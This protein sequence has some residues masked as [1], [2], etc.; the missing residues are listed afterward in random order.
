MNTKKTER[1]ELTVLNKS[2][3]LGRVAGHIRRE[4]WN[5]KRL[6][7]DE[8]NNSGGENTA[9][10]STSAATSTMEIDI[11]G[12]HTKLAQ[13]L[14]RILNLDCVVS[15]SMIQDG[16]QLV[17][18]RP[19]EREK[20][21]QT[22]KEPVK[23]P[24]K[25]P[26]VFRVLAINPGSTSTKFSIYDDETCI[27]SRTI[28]HD[29][30]QLSRC[31]AVLDQKK[32]RQD[33]IMQSLEEAGINS[34]SIDAIAGRGGL[35]KPIESGTYII[36]EKMLED[37]HSATAAIHASALGAII[38]AE[39]AGP[40]SIPAYVVDPVVVDEM[41]RNAKLT[42][43][44]GVERSSVFHALNQKAI[45]RR[46]AAKLGKSYE[47]ARFIAAHL[48]GGITVGAHRYGRVID[49]ND[50]LSGEG[51]F[52]PERTGAIPAIP[53]INMCF[54]GEYTEAEMI[55]KVT[56]NGGMKAYLGT[57]ELQN[58]QKMI[59]DGDEFAALVLD[60]MAYQV[61][62]EI[63]AMSAVLEGLVDAII[64]T[65]GLAHST[66]F[67]GAIKQRVDKIAPV[68]VFPGE[69]EMLAL[70]G[71]VLRVLRGEQQA[72]LYEA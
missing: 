35:V 1:V 66:R 23:A 53:I 10:A 34:V 71:G 3:V 20:Q 31:G 29:A 40:L 14:D 65:G 62:K 55:D 41:D 19:R 18:R 54:S 49:V 47:N 63:G 64:L 12:T 42:G 43:M 28:R 59:N 15:I 26:G 21:I 56:R 70:A 25:K 17:R 24:P 30:E 33:G 67:T 11:E 46:L 50:A 27:F 39:I 5:I 36:N 22:A 8:D 69:D 13:V 7:V 4:G 37:L 16:K 32:L 45:A 48:G 72:K 51:P 61:S 57:S 58:V 52:T 38:A 6:V 68:Y 44:P 60:S 9:A 2:G